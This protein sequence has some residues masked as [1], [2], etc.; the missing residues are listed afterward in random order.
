MVK[1]RE[2]SIKTVAATVVRRVKNL[3]DPELPNKV[4]LLPA[5]NAAP[6]PA[7]VPVCSRIIKIRANET[8]TCKTIIKV[9]KAY[10]YTNI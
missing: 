1:V 7:P 3:L 2:V 9:V 8:I 6:I 10:S 4:W 5:P